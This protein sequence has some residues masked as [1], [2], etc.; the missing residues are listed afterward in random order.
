MKT[1]QPFPIAHAGLAVICTLHLV[2]FFYLNC[3]SYC[4]SCLHEKLPNKFS[5]KWSKNCLFAD[6]TLQF[7]IKFFS[8]KLFR[9]CRIRM[10]FSCN[11]ITITPDKDRMALDELLSLND[12][13]NWCRLMLSIFANSL[14][15]WNL[16]DFFSGEFKIFDIC[17]TF[18]DRNIN[19]MAL[20]RTCF[21]RSKSMLR[22]HNWWSRKVLPSTMFS[23]EK[24]SSQLTVSFNQ[25]TLVF[26]N[27]TNRKN[28]KTMETPS[29]G[30]TWVFAL[31]E[32]PFLLWILL[33][34]RAR[35][36]TKH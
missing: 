3:F 20:I 35:K 7:L 5:Q 2:D 25:K 29:L 10:R 24:V 27:L 33:M 4:F 13:W 28:C 32:L 15:N 23:I 1:P 11:G 6:N 14:G 8:Q 18:T 9:W 16:W 34:Q 21:E 19:T 30:V 31:A 36:S 12:F 22:R 26:D 17:L